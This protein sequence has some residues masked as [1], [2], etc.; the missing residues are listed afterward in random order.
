[1]ISLLNYPRALFVI[2]LALLSDRQSGRRVLSQVQV[3]AK[4]G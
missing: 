1:M 2:T 4:C 3:P